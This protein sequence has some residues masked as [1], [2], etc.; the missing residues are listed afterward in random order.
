[1]DDTAAI[2]AAIDAAAKA[3]KG[4][5]AYVPAGSYQ[6]NKT[7]QLTGE[8]FW[9]AGSGFASSIAFPCTPPPPGPKPLPGT[10]K[11]KVVS[12][13]GGAPPALLISKASNV[14]IEQM[15]LKSGGDQLL[16]SGG[17]GIHNVRLDGVYGV[18]AAT[19]TEHWNGS[20]TIHISG[21]AAGETVHAIHLDGN[22]NV[23][24]S[25][26]GTV[27]VGMM[28]QSSLHINKG[29]AATP[30]GRSPT[31]PPPLGFLT[32]IGLVDDYDVVVQDDQSVVIEDLYC[33][34]LRTGHLLLSGSGAENTVPGRVVVQGVKSNSY[35]SAFAEIDNY[36][37][38]LYYQSSGFLEK[39][40]PAWEFTQTGSAEFNMTL[41]ANDFDTNDADFLKI[42]MGAGG[43]K[44]S[45]NLIANSASNFSDI[46]CG[47][48]SPPLPDKVAD[49]SMWLVHQA[50]DDSFAASVS[51]TSR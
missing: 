18:N 28:I 34:Q 51:E 7:L 21:L 41:I 5:M 42:T 46:A 45:L 35:T 14:S 50:L 24:D 38:S 48:A 13:A 30:A 31:D 44:G 39:S 2:Q 23:S 12:C 16:V 17:S 37:G 19:N 1:L 22:V 29:T 27:L 40:F 43:K 4:A 8:D 20:A 32:F 6:I 10:K 49:P 3:G 26:A 9:F 47:Q 36:H 33:E 25:A 15:Q 11:K